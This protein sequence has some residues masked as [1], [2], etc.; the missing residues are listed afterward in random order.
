[1]IL[2]KSYGL[3]N[4]NNKNILGYFSLILHSSCRGGWAKFKLTVNKDSLARLVYNGL[5]SRQRLR[6]MK[7][8]HYTDLNG[9]KGIIENHSL[10][11]TNMYFLN[12]EEEIRHGIAAFNNA[13]NYLGEDLSEQ[14][15]KILRKVLEEHQLFHAKHNY[16]ISF[17]QH[18]DLLSQWRGYAA[19]QGVCLEFDSEELEKSLDFGGARV[20][21]RAVFY[22][23]PDSTLEVKEELLSFIKS[24]NFIKNNGSLLYEFINTSELING[25]IPFFKHVSFSEES[26][27]RIVVQ[28]E[29]KTAPIK[30]RVNAHGLVPY[31]EIKARKNNFQSGQLPLKSLKIGPCKNRAFVAEGIEFLLKHNGYSNTLLSFTDAPFRV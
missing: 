4:H 18:S 2:R 21:S 24:E 5:L 7:I 17:C 3:N 1:M 12:D 30:F 23:Q 26:E 8:Y 14:R 11:A 9:L 10:W 13:L 29:I 31:I 15:V 16:N 27:Y 22:T 6:L 19:A 25:L 20:I 28:P